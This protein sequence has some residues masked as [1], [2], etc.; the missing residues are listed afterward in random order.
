MELKCKLLTWMLPWTLIEII[1]SLT[2][3]IPEAL[4]KYFFLLHTSS[5]P[6][7]AHGRRE[8]KWHFQPLPPPLFTFA[9]LIIFL[10]IS[11]SP[12]WFWPISAMM[13]HGWESPIILPGVQTAEA[14]WWWRT[15]GVEWIVKAGVIRCQIDVS[16]WEWMRNGGMSGDA[17]L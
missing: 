2:S 5:V 4:R 9:I 16:K 14:F 13:K 7:T 11:T 17:F 15:F 8:A 1:V 6:S 10:A 12:W 3:S